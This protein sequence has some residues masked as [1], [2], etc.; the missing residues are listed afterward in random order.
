MLTLKLIS[1]ETE[2]VIKGLNKKHF[3]G[4]EEAINE[5]LAIDKCRRETQ[6]ELDRN[7]SEAKKMAAQIG[8]LM[9]QGNK[10][11]ADDIKAKVAAIKENNKA[12]EETKA[13][14]EKDLIAK[15]CT[16]PN[17][18]ND[19]VPEGKDASD[20]VVVKEGGEIPNLPEDALCHWDLCKKFN[21]IDFDLGVKIT[22]AGFPVY[23]GKMARLQRALEAF[24]LDEARKRGK[25]D[26]CSLAQCF[27]M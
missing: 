17:I 23:I 19:D 22:G 2:R 10:Q 3:A 14:A 24:F 21:L 11:E 5:V 4:A 27:R 18:P 9:K 20:N 6:Q 26:K 15:L 16:I 1:E 12:L 13:Q 7:L 8:A 25:F